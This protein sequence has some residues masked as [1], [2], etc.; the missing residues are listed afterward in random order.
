MYVIS[1]RHPIF[2]PPVALVLLL[3]T[4]AW[5]LH[6]AAAATAR[7]ANGASM[8]ALSRCGCMAAGPLARMVC[9]PAFWAIVQ[10]FSSAECRD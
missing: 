1:P 3:V 7:H 6:L 8:C 10:A 4:V 9:M 2:M 5:L